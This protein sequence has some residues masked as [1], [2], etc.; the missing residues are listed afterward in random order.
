MSYR[1]VCCL[2]MSTVIL[3]FVLCGCQRLFLTL[4]VL[5]G[6]FGSERDG[7]TADWRKLYNGDLHDL[8]CSPD[9]VRLIRSSKMRGAG[10]GVWSLW[11]EKCMQCLKG[12]ADRKRLLVRPRRRWEVASNV[13]L[14]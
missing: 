2:R 9:V 10:R 4:G 7:V 1:P 11:G 6:V 12:G 5:W 13:R 8:C 14:K 3:R